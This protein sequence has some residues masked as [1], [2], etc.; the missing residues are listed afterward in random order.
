MVCS[1]RSHD[2]QLTAMILCC[3]M[4]SSCIASLLNTTLQLNYMYIIYYTHVRYVYSSFLCSKS[5]GSKCV[6]SIVP[7]FPQF[8]VFVFCYTETH[9]PIFLAVEPH[10]AIYAS[11][12][13]FAS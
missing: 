9:Y 6:S 7:C 4:E 12:Y 2:T 13:L 8:C 5:S 1:K 11:I 3:T 10:S